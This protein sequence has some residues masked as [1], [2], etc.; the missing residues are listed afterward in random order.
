MNK[1]P[2][3][4]LERLQRANN[5]QK[6]LR[7]NT[8]TAEKIDRFFNTGYL[9]EAYDL[10]LTSYEK[11]TIPSRDPVLLPPTYPTQR[12]VLNDIIDPYLPST[13]YKKAVAVVAYC[14]RGPGDADIWSQYKRC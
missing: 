13:Y 2:T 5:Q 10:C 8:L 14:L 3:N 12:D 7:K 6:R 4:A 9:D 1:K 11:Q